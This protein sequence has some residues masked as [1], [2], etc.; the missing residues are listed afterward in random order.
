MSEELKALD[1]AIEVDARGT[2]CPG[3]LLEAKRAIADCPV[4]GVMCV[5]S[6]DEGTIIDIQRWSKKMKHEYVG[7]YED[8]GFWRVY[9]KK[10]G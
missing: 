6:S 2:A 1:V 10:L 9:M 7:D 8:D 3:P 5:L 4:D